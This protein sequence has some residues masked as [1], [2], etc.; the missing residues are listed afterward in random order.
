MVWEFNSSEVPPANS[1]SEE[2]L[3][4]SPQGNQVGVWRQAE[5]RNLKVLRVSRKNA[6]TVLS[7]SRPRRRLNGFS[8]RSGKRRDDGLAPSPARPTRDSESATHAFDSG[9]TE[10][11]AGCLDELSFQATHVEIM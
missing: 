7:L 2:L 10:P 1:L 8:L 9:G 3:L 5:G 4:W 11:K 6:Q